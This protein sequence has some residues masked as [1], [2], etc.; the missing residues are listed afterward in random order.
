MGYV[1]NIYRGSYFYF[2]LDK[3]D[4][5]T[6]NLKRCCEVLHDF[7]FVPVIRQDEKR[8]LDAIELRKEFASRGMCVDILDNE[9]VS[10]LE[11]LVML[12]IRADSEWV[13]NGG[14]DPSRI[15]KEMIMN[16]F[17]KHFSG[18]YTME[19]CVSEWLERDFDF[20]GYGS[21]FPLFKAYEDQRTSTLWLQMVHYV[22]ENYG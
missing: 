2:L 20:D 22:N 3:V 14:D 6:V 19:E 10:A 18:G 15:F 11:V 12:A 7:E 1:E 5:D 8:M 16:L 9:N 13:G 4:C 21:P 17:K